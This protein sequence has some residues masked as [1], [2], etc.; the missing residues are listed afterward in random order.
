MPAAL[1]TVHLMSFGRLS[2]QSTNGEV[3]SPVPTPT[4]SRKGSWSLRSSRATGDTPDAAGKA[5][6]GGGT[7][8]AP[9]EPAD[10]SATTAGMR[11]A[12][13]AT[14]ANGKAAALGP[15]SPENA[16]AEEAELQPRNLDD[17]RLPSKSLDASPEGLESDG[18]RQPPQRRSQEQRPAAKDLD[19][20]TREAQVLSYSDRIDVDGGSCCRI[21]LCCTACPPLNAGVCGV[22]TAAHQIIGKCLY[23]SQQPSCMPKTLMPSVATKVDGAAHWRK[24]AAEDIGA[25]IAS[26]REFLG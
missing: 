9:A 7:P 17:E 19:Q 10:T 20:L 21:H 8:A 12:T 15:T 24:T 11:A 23:R 2:L 16:E 1:G 5:A 6:D 22:N 26:T 14:S 13:S 18:A 4:A 3:A 25:L